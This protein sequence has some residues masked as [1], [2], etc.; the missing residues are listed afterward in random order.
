MLCGARLQRARHPPTARAR[1]ARSARDGAGPARAAAPARGA[2]ARYASSTSRSPRRGRCRRPAPGARPRRPSAVGSRTDVAHL[3]AAPLARACLRFPAMRT[4]A[5]ARPIASYRAA[6]SAVRTSASVTASSRG[7][8]PGAACDSARSCATR[9]GRW[10]S[11]PA[12]RRG[13]GRQ[14]DGPELVSRRMTAPGARGGSR[15]RGSTPSRSAAA[16]SSPSLAVRQR[17][18]GDPPAVGREGR[19]DDA[20]PGRSRSNSPTRG[21][22]AR[23]SPTEAAWIQ[24]SRRAPRGRA[25]APVTGRAAEALAQPPP[26]R[27]DKGGQH[28]E[29]ATTRE[30]RIW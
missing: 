14:Q 8:I 25:R 26:Q 1:P 6:S 23:T 15:D 9:S 16:G 2:Q 22:A 30:P 13:A 3:P 11:A 10:R 5:G 17:P 20:R 27:G 28:Q 29:D 24:S 21:A 19:D 18:G 7:R 4:R 12:P